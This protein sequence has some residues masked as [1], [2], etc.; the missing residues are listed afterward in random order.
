MTMVEWVQRL[1]A[2]L[3]FNDRS[4]L[5]DVGRVSHALAEERA[6]EE[7]AL[8]R[9][10]QVEVSDFDEVVARTPSLTRKEEP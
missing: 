4:V 7:L 3:A 9:T 6:E 8:F 2:F 5:T 10:A 1:D